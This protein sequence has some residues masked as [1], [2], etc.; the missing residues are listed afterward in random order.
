MSCV[1]HNETKVFK[2]NE[3]IRLTSKVPECCLGV[4]ILHQLCVQYRLSNYSPNTEFKTNSQYFQNCCSE[5][6]SPIFSWFYFRTKHS[7]NK[8]FMSLGFE[9][10]FCCYNILSYYV[11]VSS[12]PLLWFFRTVQFLNLWLKTYE[13][14]NFPNV[15]FIQRTG[16]FGLT[17]VLYWKQSPWNLME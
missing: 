5:P 3:Y 16:K 14:F 1:I 2:V 7:F 11:A 12:T 17:G 4:R 8:F 6:S 10:L 13:K 9:L 15:D